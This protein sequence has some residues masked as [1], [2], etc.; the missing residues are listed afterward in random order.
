MD[1]RVTY[2]NQKQNKKLNSN[3]Q[4]SHLRNDVDRFDLL[5]K[6][7]IEYC[8]DVTIQPLEKYIYIY[9]YIYNKT[10]TDYTKQESYQQKEL[11]NKQKKNEQISEMYRKTIV[12]ILQTM[13]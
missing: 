4:V 12:R 8:V 3:G 9:I 7:Y 10:K 2:T 1:K 13:N 6:Y 5:R 11:K